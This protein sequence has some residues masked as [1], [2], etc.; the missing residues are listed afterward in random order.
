MRRPLTLLS[1]VLLAPASAAADLGDNDLGINTHLPS[2]DLLDMSDDLGVGWIRVDANWLQ[3]Q[4]TASTFAWSEMDRVVDEANTRGLRVYM[5][6][7]YTPDWVPVEV[8]GGDAETNNDVPTTSTEW[9]A[10]VEAA[11][12]RYSARGVTHFGIWNEPNLDH[13]WAGTAD[14]YIDRILVPGAAAVRAT[15]SGCTVLGPDLAHVGDYDG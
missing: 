10:F 3:L 14:Q 5:T 4:P 12:A 15:C 13:F 6:L 1:L 9:V 7:A 11:V 2:N 8:T